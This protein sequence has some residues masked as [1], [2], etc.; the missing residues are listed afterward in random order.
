MIAQ[1]RKQPR[2]DLISRLVAAEER[3]DALSEDEML[4]TVALLLVAG[5]ETTTHLI[6]TG[7]LVL[8]RNPDQMERLRADPSL[9][10]SAVEEIL[11]YA[12]PVHTT[13]RVARAN[14]TL[15]GA[16]I[17][18][19]DVVITLLAAAN[20]DPAKYLDPDRFDIARNPTDHL[21]F[22]DGIHFCLG[23]AL[24][25]LEAQIAIGTLLRRFANLR[26]LDEVEWAGT[27]GGRTAV[28]AIRGVARLRVAP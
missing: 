13:R 4:G 19:G 8:F 27:P 1:R 3:G 6:S 23:A 20:R 22:G 7:M 10:P 18:S 5:N 2:D 21:A 12:G 11:R 28:V 17:E 26:L 15:S 9:L 25:R 14:V 16:E 24:A